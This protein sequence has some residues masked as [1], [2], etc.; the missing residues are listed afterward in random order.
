MSDL[1]KG[2]LNLHQ[3]LESVKSLLLPR[4]VTQMSRMELRETAEN[5]VLLANLVG[6]EAKQACEQLKRATKTLDIPTCDM[7][8]LKPAW[9]KEFILGLS[10]VFS[11]LMKNN[12]T[13]QDVERAKLKPIPDETWLHAVAIP[14]LLQDAL[15]GVNYVHF[16]HTLLVP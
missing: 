9:R 1:E 16:G 7:Q 3:R 4:Y 10:A 6:A 5:A 12:L 14:K 2:T 15:I 13:L 11:V 8:I